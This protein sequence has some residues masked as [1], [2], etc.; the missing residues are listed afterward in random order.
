MLE[1]ASA[2][3]IEGVPFMKDAVAAYDG[4]A[5][6]M[7]EGFSFSDA[8][9]NY[10]ENLDEINKDINQA[11]K[12]NPGSFM[13]GDITGGVSTLSLGAGFK[14]AAA[15]GAASG[16]SRSE[17]RSVT[18]AVVGATVGI[19][20]EGVMR[21]GG[22]VIKKGGKY[23]MD[24]ADDL[25]ANAVKKILGIDNVSMS[26]Q[27]YKHLKRTNQKESD[28]LSDVLTKK[29]KDGDEL[30]VDFR[31]K[32]QRMLEKI[33]LKRRELGEDLGSLYKKVDQEFDVKINI[34]D[35]KESLKD[36]IL[37]QFKLSDDPGMQDIGLD[38]EKYIERIGTK[39]SAI[40]EEVTPEGTKLIRDITS[41]DTFNLSRVH[42][43]QKDIRKRIESIYRKNGLDLNASKEQQ[44]QV[45]S[46][47]GRH[48]DEILETVST[49]DKKIMNT[50]MK[51]R[52]E[53]GNMATIEEAVEKLTF[54]KPDDPMSQ[55]K[56][57][58]QMRSIFLSGAGYGVAGPAGA[59]AGAGLNKIINSPKTPVYLA[60]GLKKVGSIMESMPAGRIA[61]KINTAAML[62]NDAFRDKV[63]GVV[64]EVN[65]TTQP[66]ARSAASVIERQADF[67]HIIKS[68][69]PTSLADFEEAIE[70]GNPETINAFM[71]NISKTPEVSKFFEQGIGFD[72]KVYNEEDKMQL[73]RQVRQTDMPAIQRIEMLDNLRK[74]NK[75]PDLNNIVQLPAKGH[76]PRTKKVHD[77]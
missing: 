19:A 44:R 75:I 58:L 47:L 77:Y 20:G 51:K 24:K 8:Y 9:G 12:D 31:D 66:V 29:M 2:G 69:L 50:V 13:V 70:S 33:G 63:Y 26:K 54:R 37:P 23:L 7:E 18:D 39:V 10:K 3:F 15:V 28:F 68:E 17:D 74:E 52:K 16:L 27:V 76:V 55:L 38:L 59:A 22:Q 67:R 53:F 48:M 14:G 56:E 32:P 43:L 35:L 30:V 6:S 36:D 42:K 49:P 73:E 1:S 45:A 65:L 40:K 5:E 25:G 64:A 72:G 61:S 60:E 71:D 11:E 62:Q 41:E 34:D 21:V 57:L 46:S 4:M